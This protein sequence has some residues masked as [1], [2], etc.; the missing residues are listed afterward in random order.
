VLETRT[1]RAGGRVLEVPARFSFGD[2]RGGL[3][4]T[5]DVTDAHLT[6]MERPQRT[7]FVQMRGEATVTVN[8]RPAGRLPG[9]FETYLD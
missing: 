5:V 2:A 1:R 9:F 4:V 7:W 3:E 8:G 6:D